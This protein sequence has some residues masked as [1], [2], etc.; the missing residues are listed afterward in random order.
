MNFDKLVTRIL[1]EN[2]SNLTLPVLDGDREIYTLN[3]DMWVTISRLGRVEHN[4]D[5]EAWDNFDYTVD[6]YKQALEVML[7]FCKL[8]AQ[9][10]GVLTKQ[11]EEKQAL[12]IQRLEPIKNIKGIWKAGRTTAACEEFKIGVEVDRDFYRMGG[13]MQASSDIA[14]QTDSQDISTW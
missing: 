14:N 2:V 3:V 7:N 11:L 5:F 8:R 6:S 13:L 10:S 4:W 9:Y 1:K 12:L